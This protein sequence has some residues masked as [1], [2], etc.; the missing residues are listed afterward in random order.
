MGWFFAF[1]EELDRYQRYRMYALDIDRDP[2]YRFLEATHGAYQVGLAILLYLWGGWSC[3]LWGFVL[4]TVVMWHATWLVNSAAHTWGYRTWPVD[5]RSTNNW[6]VALMTFGEGWHNNHHAFPRSA[7]HGLRWWE[8]DVT[9]VTI[10][11]LAILR[12]AKKI[13]LPTMEQKERW[14]GSSCIPDKKTLAA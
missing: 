1:D 5:D 6:W 8:L 14:L 2:F 10:R 9:Y 12:L 11:M 3:V 4:R 7:A 13:I